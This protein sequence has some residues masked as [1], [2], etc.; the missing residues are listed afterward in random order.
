MYIVLGYEYIVTKFIE[1]V[2]LW[3]YEK[4][5]V[6]VLEKINRLP[7]KMPVKKKIKEEICLFPHFMFPNSQ[8]WSVVK[9]QSVLLAYILLAYILIANIPLD[10][11]CKGK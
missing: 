1:N 10:Y 3:Y 5:S 6:N 11:I 9:L 4:N 2:W 7:A 8:T